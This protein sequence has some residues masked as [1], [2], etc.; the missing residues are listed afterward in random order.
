MSEAGSWLE[1]LKNALLALGAG[2]G[3]LTALL[4]YLWRDETRRLQA[5][6]ETRI[7]RLEAVE[8]ALS[9]ATKAAKLGIEVNE[10]SKRDLQSG[11]QRI[12]HEFGDPVTLS[13]EALEEWAKWPWVD[14][15]Q[16]NV[17]FTVPEY[18]RQAAKTQ[19]HLSWLL[20]LIFFLLQI[21]VP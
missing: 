2:L 12:V 20:P 10:I 18:Y 3:L 11:L 17:K 9:V 5:E 4:P 1:I 13:R 7:K 16:T 19:R 14:R 6:A 15:A 21:P 8:K